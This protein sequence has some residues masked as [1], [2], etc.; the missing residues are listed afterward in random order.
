MSQESSADVNP[1]LPNCPS[2]PSMRGRPG[3]AACS[4]RAGMTAAR[5]IGQV[6]NVST[7]W[8]KRRTRRRRPSKHG[9]LDS[10]RSV[11]QLVTTGSWPRRSAVRQRIGLVTLVV[12]DYDEAMAYFTEKLG[13][14]LVQDTPV[15]AGKRWV[16]VAPQGGAGSGLLLAQ[17]ADERQR[18]AVG[19]RPAAGCF[20]SSTRMTSSATMPHS[21]DGALPSSGSRGRSTTGPSPCSPTSTAIAGI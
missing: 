13:F 10:G 1:R 21:R 2:W 15:E 3:P 11:V 20:S 17:A 4:G 16:V 9:A 5:G 6:W 19:P 18:Q 12:D 14:A 7:A 8:P